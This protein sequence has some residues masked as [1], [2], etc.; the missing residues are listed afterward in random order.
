LVVLAAVAAGTFSG[1]VAA[2]DFVAGDSVVV[3]TDALNLRAGAGLSYAVVDVLAWGTS[4]TVTDGPTEADGYGWYKV[5]V[6][7]GTSGWVAGEFLSRVRYS[8]QYEAGDV[9]VVDTAA[10]NCRVG[11]GLDYAVDHVMA[12]G[13]EVVVLDGPVGADGYHWYQLEMANGDVAWAIGEGLAPAGEDDNGGS[14]EPAFA[15]G[16]EVV[17]ATDALNLRIG[18]GLDKAV[19]DVL[20]GGT[21]L[22]VSNG[23]MA[24][25]GHAWYEVETRD[26]RLGWVAGAYL[27][28]A[29]GGGFAVGDAVRVAGGALNL[30]A[31]PDLSATVLR[32]MADNEALLVRGGPVAADG[33]TWYRVWNYGGEGWAAGE[34][35]RFDPNGFPAEEGA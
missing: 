17:V 6:G 16:S 25:D 27:A 13:S 18:A 19:T 5:R 35:L 9:A 31:E 26:G 30:R 28:T 23:P 34:Y 10:L 21:V 4:L 1:G 32:V 11:P 15:K 33:Y 24:A 2:A 14:Q 12:G 29:S 8:T 7:D 20:P 3:D 22:L